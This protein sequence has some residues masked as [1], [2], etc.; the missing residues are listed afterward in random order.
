MGGSIPAYYSTVELGESFIEH[1][2]VKGMKWGVRKEEIPTTHRFQSS[3]IKI[4]SGVPES[5]KISAKHIAS[6]MGERYGL[7]IDA[8]NSFGPG[9]PE[10]QMGTIAYVQTGHSNTINVT[11]KD[12]RNML[13]NNERDGW[14]GKDC[15]NLNA[16]LTHE[17][18]HAV[19]HVP[20]KLK[21]KWYGP[22]IV[23]GEFKARNKALDAMLKAARKEP[24]A[25]RQRNIAAMV[26]GYAQMSGT[27]EEME[28]ELFSQYHWNSDPPNFVKVWGETLHEAMGVDKTPFV[29]QAVS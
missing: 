1:Y 23:G 19:F 28:A 11:Q 10:Y 13:K 18:A 15:G 24:K 22:T 9:H 3:K 5:T 20:Q 29:K 17:S 7:R 12:V 8:I 6:L 2:G 16:L 4:D 26:S 14:L 21:V 27:R 25:T